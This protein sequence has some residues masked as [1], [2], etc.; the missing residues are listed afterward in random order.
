MFF[1]N[2][3]NLLPHQQKECDIFKYIENSEEIQ[4]LK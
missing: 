1:E 2:L 4:S 3:F